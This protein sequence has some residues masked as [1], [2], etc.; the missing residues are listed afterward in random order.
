MRPEGGD[1]GGGH[2][3]PDLATAAKALNLDRST[4]W[5]YLD[6]LEKELSGRLVHRSGKRRRTTT[7]TTFGHHVI[8]AI[9]DLEHATRA[10]DSHS[11]HSDEGP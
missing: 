8:Q 1:G 6:R 7:P 9:R 3:H 5:N 4:I 10:H 2:V 11:A